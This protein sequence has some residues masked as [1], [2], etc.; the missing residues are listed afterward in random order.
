M[1]DIDHKKRFA[2]NR[3]AYKQQ[4]NYCVTLLGENKEQLR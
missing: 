3:A 2:Q 4:L 1:R